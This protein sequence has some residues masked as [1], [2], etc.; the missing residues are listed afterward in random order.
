[1][2]PV[3]CLIVD[4]DPIKVERL[5]SIIVN[6]IGTDE[7]SINEAGSAN[8]AAECSGLLRYDLLI[9]D[10]N[11]RLQGRRPSWRRWNKASSSGRSWNWKPFA[12]DLRD[13]YNCL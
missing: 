6:E 4:D 10:V 11:C 1:M 12:A 8:E 5:R 13:W 3:N 7:V 2:E 9:V